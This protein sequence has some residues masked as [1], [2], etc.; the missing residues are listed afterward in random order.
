MHNPTLMMR[1]EQTRAT[2]AVFLK[3]VLFSSQGTGMQKSEAKRYLEEHTSLA[4]EYKM[5]QGKG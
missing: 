5:K 2:S 1:K 4:L 3:Q